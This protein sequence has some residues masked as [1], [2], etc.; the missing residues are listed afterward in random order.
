[1]AE[2]VAPGWYQDPEDDGKVRFWDGVCWTDRR[3]VNSAN[4][5]ANGWYQHPGNPHMHSEFV[6]GQW[7][8]RNR[9]AKSSGGVVAPK[10]SGTKTCQDCGEAVSVTSGNCQLCGAAQ[11]LP[12]ALFGNSREAHEQRRQTEAM[13]GV[14]WAVIG[15]V[16]FLAG[17]LL[18]IVNNLRFTFE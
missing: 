7:T 11:F 10:I 15:G 4:V 8:G 17:L 5:P 6:D 2:N 14:R 3:K 9:K 12:F 1:M 13:N 18:Y 16:I